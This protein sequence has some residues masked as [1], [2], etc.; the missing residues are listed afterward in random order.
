[1]RTRSLKVGFES[2]S[3]TRTAITCQT[4]LATSN[5]NRQFSAYY[6]IKRSERYDKYPASTTDK[7]TSICS[8]H[9]RSTFKRCD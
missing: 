6:N 2:G 5:L 3:S 4:R 8:R 1:M 9:G 7:N